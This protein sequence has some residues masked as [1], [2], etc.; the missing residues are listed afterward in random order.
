VVRT[1]SGPNLVVLRNPGCH[2]ARISSEILFGSAT[3]LTPKL[4]KF[5]DD[6]NM[7]KMKGMTQEMDEGNE[8]RVQDE[9]NNTTST[10]K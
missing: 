5:I 7:C 9:G 10:V 2:T 1:T 6:K 8:A 4:D 3:K